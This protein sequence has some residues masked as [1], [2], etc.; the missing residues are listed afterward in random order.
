MKQLYGVGIGPGKMDCM[1]GQRCAAQGDFSVCLYNPS[2]R[3]IADYL[4]KA[5]AILM[6]DKSSDTVCGWV[7]NIGRTGECAKILSLARLANE[8]LDMFTTVFVGNTA[9]QNCGGRMVTPRGYE[10]KK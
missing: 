3:K 8:E 5:C 2:S 1:T 6:E 7:K 9:T 10:A 4:Q